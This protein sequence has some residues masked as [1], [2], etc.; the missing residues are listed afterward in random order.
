MLK[1]ECIFSLRS[2]LKKSKMSLS[3]FRYAIVWKRVYSYLIHYCWR[4]LE[5]ILQRLILHSGDYLG[6]GCCPYLHCMVV[7]M[8]AR[9][10]N[11]VSFCHWRLAATAFR[12]NRT[13]P[14]RRIWSPGMHVLAEAKAVNQASLPPFRP[15][16]DYLEGYGLNFCND[17]ARGQ[18]FDWRLHM[19]WRRIIF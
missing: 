15:A 9:P 12:T 14:V 7:F 16:L 6:C 1:K 17:F 2:F 13:L 4:W 11:P 8:L 10:E 19:L 5:L 18:V 3:L